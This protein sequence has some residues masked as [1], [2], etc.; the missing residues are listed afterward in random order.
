MEID[1]WYDLARRDR[2]RA[3]RFLLL[4][5]TVGLGRLAAACADHLACR[6][7]VPLR[8]CDVLATW[9]RVG[10]LDERQARAAAGE[11]A[12]RR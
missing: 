4:H 5:D 12:P 10:L 11:G 2:R 8:R 1:A 6:Y 7:G 9:R 3:L